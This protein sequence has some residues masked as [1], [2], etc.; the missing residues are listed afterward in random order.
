MNTDNLSDIHKYWQ[1]LSVIIQRSPLS[2][3]FLLKQPPPAPVPP[4]SYIR[5]LLK[6]CTSLQQ[7][8]LFQRHVLSA[9]VLFEDQYNQQE[10]FQQISSLEKIFPDI[11]LDDMQSVSWI[12][13]PLAVV[14]EH[15]AVKISILLGLKPGS[16]KCIV[17]CRPQLSR[18]SRQALE[19][20]VPDGNDLLVWTMQHESDS[21]LTGHS[22]G[23]PSAIGISLLQNGRKWPQQLLATGVLASDGYIKAV[24]HIRK[25][26]R[27]L[28][29]D[30]GLFLVPVEN[31]NMPDS[32]GCMVA[33]QTVNDAI[34]VVNHLHQGVH[35]PQTIRLFQLAAQ[36][37]NSLLEL[38]HKLPIE[39]FTLHDLSNVYETIRNNPKKYIKKLVSCLKN[40]KNL[41]QLPNDLVS[42]FT[43]DEIWNMAQLHPF[44]ALKYSLAQLTFQNHLGRT[45]K[46]GQWSC[47]ADKIAVSCDAKR[48]L[49]PL[50]NN[51]FVNTRFNRYDFRPELPELFKRRL[52]HEKRLHELQ[53]DDSWQLGAMYGTLAQNFGF[54][55]P[56]YLANLEEM[57]EKA[58]SAFGR[59]FST[60][61]PRILS[62]QL[63]GFLDNDQFTEANTLFA[64]VLS[65]TDT[66][67]ESWIR[68]IYAGCSSQQPGFPF[69]TTLL[70]RLLADQPKLLDMCSWKEIRQYLI[71]RVFLENQ[72]PWQLTAINLA[73]CCLHCHETEQAVKLLDYAVSV[74]RKHGATMRAMG[75]LPLALLH[76]HNLSG[77]THIRLAE[78]LIEEIQI[79]VLD[80]S[81]FADLFHCNGGGEVLALVKEREKVF[82]PFSYR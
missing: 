46:S 82:F 63:Y 54:C 21:P 60:E 16:G 51:D 28:P 56:A 44:S 42:M 61:H 71:R 23:L 4:V 38:F 74:C 48:D 45:V 68:K 66:N 67:P 9:I 39:F 77:T 6:L 1:D 5:H 12:A 36:D 52:E 40:K 11:N 15:K 22:L 69:T 59:R 41:T 13:V 37:A 26:K 17:Q 53:E 81:H 7:K 55:G 10:Q 25:K 35:D 47:L 33:V 78:K 27:L 49:T 14:R 32:D 80:Q 73:R 31:N 62:Y 65:L 43:C 57:T 24:Q 3:N 79:N 18:S 70:C 19:L 64:K 72:H 29:K 75:L 34:S 58:I 30:A 20:L 8:Q 76:E 2:S 50:A